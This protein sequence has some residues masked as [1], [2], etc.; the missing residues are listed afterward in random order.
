MGQ[1]PQHGCVVAGAHRDPGSGGTSTQILL[2]VLGV[3][4]RWTDLAHPGAVCPLQRARIR[5]AAWGALDPPLVLVDANPTDRTDFGPRGP[6]CPSG[7]G[8]FV[9][10]GGFYGHGG[11]V[12]QQAPGSV[13][14]LGDGL[15]P[16]RGAGVRWSYSGDQSGRSAHLRA[17]ARI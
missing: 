3:G 13:S 7:S 14:C 6:A 11:L 15:D 9:G 12:L 17:G 16:L 8:A 10:H 2:T 1:P 4:G 5:P